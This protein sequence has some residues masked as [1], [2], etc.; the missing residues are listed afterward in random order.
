MIT[1]GA[2]MKKDANTD[3]DETIETLL[4]LDGEQYRS[5]SGFWVKFDIKRVEPSPQIPHGIKYSLTLHDRNGT[6]VLGYDNAHGIKPKSRKGFHGRRV[7]W[8]HAH[9][10]QHIFPY[11]FKSAGDLLEDFWQEVL[12]FTE[13]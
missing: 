4:D 11:E 1:I 2:E 6:R 9:R 13:F 3:A 5:D 10:R 12:R 8:D 7:V